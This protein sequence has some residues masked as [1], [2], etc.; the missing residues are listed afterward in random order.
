MPMRGY[1]ACVRPALHGGLSPAEKGA[2]R[3]LTPEAAM[4]RSTGFAPE[5]PI[6]RH[7]KRNF[8]G[9]SRQASFYVNLRLLR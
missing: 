9:G 1:A 6:G 7:D 5:A 2:E 4:T 8:R 3:T